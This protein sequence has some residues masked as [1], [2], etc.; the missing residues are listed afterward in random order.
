MALKPSLEGE[1]VVCIFFR[2]S[3][4]RIPKVKGSAAKSHYLKALDL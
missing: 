1:A 4:A 2:S 3:G